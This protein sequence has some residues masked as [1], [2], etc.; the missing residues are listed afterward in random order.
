MLITRR[1]R[2]V[3]HLCGRLL[4]LL[5][6]V[7]LWLV[8]LSAPLF[9]QTLTVEPSCGTPGS[10]VKIGGSGWAEPQPVCDYFFFFDG[11]EFAPSQ[12]DGLLGPPNQT[13]TIPMTATPGDHKIKVELRLRENNALL[14]CRQTKFKVV[15]TNANPF[16]G[17]NVQPAAGSSSATGSINFTFDPKDVCDV[18][19]CTRLEWIQSLKIVGVR[20]DSTTGVLTWA[21]VGFTA[22]T[23]DQ[24]TQNGVTIDQ[25]FGYPKPYY[26][27]NS[28]GNS[29]TS[30]WGQ[31]GVQNGSPRSANMRDQ[32][33][34][35]GVPMG[36][37]KVR[38]E[39]ESNVFCAEGQNRGTFPGGKVLWTWESTGGSTGTA[40]VVSA[41]RDQPSQ[42]FLDALTKWDTNHATWAM[43]TPGPATTG[44]EACQ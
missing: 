11:V 7:L 16:A 31:S 28:S 24:D 37:D 43:P 44:G 3:P 21:D 4:T 1:F 19:P 20:A 8:I 38:G 26:V 10:S 35:W 18:T 42:A 14:Q 27:S 23:F 2:R 6:Q 9:A 12:P 36:F 17:T 33:K 29:P 25:L 41:T 32:P 13:G 30:G 15:A 5:I 34:N 39:F 22:N 40:T